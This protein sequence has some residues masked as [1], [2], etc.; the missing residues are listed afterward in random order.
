MVILITPEKIYCA[1]CGDSRAILIRKNEVVPLSTDHKPNN[2]IELE[3]IRKNYGYVDKNGRLNGEVALAR[4]FGDIK[5]HPALSCEPEITI[6]RRREDDL[7]LVMACDGVWDVFDNETVGEF[8]RERIS[9]PRI[10]DVACFLR[11]AA[12]YSDSGDNITCIVT[13]L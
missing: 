8:V 13:R 12:H 6:N 10:A 7:A 1:N 11:D 2:P 5:C 3:R 4:A 9:L